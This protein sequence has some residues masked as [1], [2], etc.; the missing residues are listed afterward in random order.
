MSTGGHGHRSRASRSP[1]TTGSAATRVGSA[2]TFADVS[3]IDETPIAEVARGESRRS[4]PRPSPPR[5]AGSHVWG[6]MSAEGSSR[7]PAPDRRRRRGARPRARR[8][9]D[10]RQ[11]V[12]APFACGTRSCRASRAT[13]GSSPTS[14]S[15][16]GHDDVDFNG[17]A[18]H[19]A[20]DPSGVDRGDHAVERPADA[21]DLARR[22]G[23]G[24]RQHRGPQ[25]AGVGAAHGVDAGRHRA[26]CRPPRRRVQRRAG[27]RRGGGRR[28][29]GAPRRGPHRVHRL[30]RRPASSWRRPPAPNLT[31]VSPG[32][33]RQ[34]AVRRVRR[35][36]PGRASSSRRSASSTTPGRS[37]WPAP[38]C[39][40]RRRSSTSSWT[41]SSRRHRQIRQ[42]DPRDEATDIGPQITREH[43]ERVDGFVRRADRRRRRARS[44]AADRTT[45][46]GACTTDP[47]LFADAPA[48]SEI[49]HARGLRPGPHRAAVRRR[50]RGR[51]RW[52]TTPTTAWPRSCTRATR[53]RAE[54]VSAALVAGTVWVNCFF[55]RDLAA[56]FGGSRNSRDRPRGRHLELRLLRG[57]E[58]RL[59][60]TVDHRRRGETHMGEIVG[61][62]L[63]AHVPTIMLPEDDAARDQRRQGDHA[64]ARP[65]A[66]EDRGASTG[67]SPTP[68]SCSTRTGSRR[69]STSSRRPNGAQ[70]KF[71]SHELPRGMS[72]DPYDMPG[73]PELANAHREAGRGPRRLLDPR[74]RRSVPADLLRHGERL[75]VPGRRRHAV[76]QRGDQPVL[77]D[78]GLPAV[79]AS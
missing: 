30:G 58:E 50:G 24:G 75:D 13:S 28:A 6:A 14:C 76:D 68:S 17:F 60:R 66:A 43:F 70:G 54:R 7:G 25:A 48:G 29:R 16:S 77:H 79:R 38:A 78:R 20:W 57:R 72:A 45:T 3:P 63:V 15:S 55:V 4:R 37:V 64:G 61:A 39:W 5:V 51:S 53:A 34:V 31:P 19:F 32:A 69:S 52:R 41:G 36:R 18:E 49:L 33:R 27:D 26:R 65:A 11:R 9:R 10:A 46:S 44:S 62:A 23:A 1:P 22:A 35:R 73:D 56:P 8:G 2:G 40:W 67:C 59:H 74:L 42:G 21:R 12:A 47:T 71:T